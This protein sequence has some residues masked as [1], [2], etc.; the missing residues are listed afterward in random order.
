MAVLL[1]HQLDNLQCQLL[2]ETCN[3]TCRMIFQHLQ[4]FFFFS[5]FPPLCG[6]TLGTVATTGLLYQPWMV[7]GGGDCGVIG[8]M[9]IGGGNRS[10]RR[11]PAPV[12][13]CPP[14]IPHD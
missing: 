4:S 13:L 11:K 7:G 8:G 2:S 10:T 12:P 1:V 5:S 3:M 9:K 6:G 14:Q